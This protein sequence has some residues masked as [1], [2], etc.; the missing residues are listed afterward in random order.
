MA[1]VRRGL[2]ESPQKERVTIACYHRL[3]SPLVIIACD[4]RLL[5]SLVIVAVIIAATAP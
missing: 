1:I 2:G 5:S 3:L 4:H